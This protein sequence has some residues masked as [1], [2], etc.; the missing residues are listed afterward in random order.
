MFLSYMAQFPLI[1]MLSLSF[2]N[3]NWWQID[4]VLW[5]N[6]WVKG[7]LNVN[8]NKY[9]IQCS[10]VKQTPATCFCNS[11]LLYTFIRHCP[12]HLILMHPLCIVFSWHPFSFHAAAKRYL[13][14][15]YAIQWQIQTKHWYLML[16]H[17]QQAAALWAKNNMTFYYFIL[18]YELLY[19]IFWDALSSIFYL[20]F[21]IFYLTYISVTCLFVILVQFYMKMSFGA[22]S[23]KYFKYNITYSTYLNRSI[24]CYIKVWADFYK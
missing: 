22:R 4:K 9:N 1:K 5:D 16:L 21:F 12:S 13:Q 14:C 10:L 17:W 2:V 20:L 8:I 6:S 23:L 24:P 19:S 3:L 15:R 18:L 11:F 7:L